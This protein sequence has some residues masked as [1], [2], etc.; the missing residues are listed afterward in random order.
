MKYTHL[1]YQVPVVPYT[2]VTTFFSL[3]ACLPTL[4]LGLRTWDLGSWH[5]SV[6]LVTHLL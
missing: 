5:F 4:S 1:G 6:H 2:R 3:P